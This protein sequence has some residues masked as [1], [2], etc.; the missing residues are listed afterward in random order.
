MTDTTHHRQVALN[1][2]R[3]G[4]DLLSNVHALIYVGDQI[5]RI[6]DAFEPKPL[7]DEERAI[8]IQYAQVNEAEAYLRADIARIERGGPHHASTAKL[9]EE[10]ATNGAL[11]ARIDAEAARLHT[12]RLQG[13]AL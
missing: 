6:A 12:R 10:L 3:T 8:E 1:L 4:S 2:A 7:T 9:R 13:A 5:A 11:R